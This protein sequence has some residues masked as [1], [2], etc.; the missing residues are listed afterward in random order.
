VV[1]SAPY[2]MV[3]ARLLAPAAPAP[4]THRVN[5]VLLRIDGMGH[6][7]NIQSIEA[8]GTRVIRGCNLI[9]RKP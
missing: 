9:A 3:G 5:E 2:F 4:A 8:F 1:E 7:I 6:E